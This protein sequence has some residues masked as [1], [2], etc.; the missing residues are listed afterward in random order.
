MAMCVVCYP[1]DPTRDERQQVE[2]DKLSSSSSEVARVEDVEGIPGICFL[3]VSVV[4]SQF[5]SNI[6]WV[7]SNFISSVIQ[8]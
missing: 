7:S 1:V 6:F 5:L 3:T 2:E 4:L 8:Y